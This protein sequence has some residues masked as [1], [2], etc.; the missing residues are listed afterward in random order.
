MVVKNAEELVKAQVG[1]PPPGGVSRWALIGGESMLGDIPMPDKRQQM[2]IYYEMYRQHP[3]VRAAV[4]KKAQYASSAKVLFRP[5]DPETKI[6]QYKVDKLKL[7]FRRSNVKQLLR[8]TYKDLDI[9]GESFWLVLR[10]FAREGTPQKA[11]RLNPRYMTPVVKNGLVIEW[12]YG[13]VSGSELPERYKPEQIL[14]FRLDDPENDVAGLSPLHSLQRAVAQDLFAMEYNESFFK[15]SAQTGTIFIVKTSTEAEAKR[16]RQW[17]KENY[18]GPD[19]AHR[20]LLLEGDVDVEKSVSTPQEMEFLRGRMLL[21]QEIAMVL[22]VDLE[23][24]GVHESSNR[25]VSNEV[26][27]SFHSESVWPR[28]V[29]LEEE[30]NNQLIQRI[31]GWSDIVFEQ[32]DRDPRRTQDQADTDDKNLKSGRET[33]NIQRERLGLAPVPGGDLAFVMTPTG[34]LFVK[35]FQKLAERQTQDGEPIQSEGGVGSSQS[36]TPDAT[37][38]EKA[39]TREPQTRRQAE[40]TSQND[41]SR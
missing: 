21:R 37:S 34:I 29:I 25:S 32:E 33:I 8:I 9:Y 35:N 4:D 31:F 3:V 20:P 30:I 17:L 39:P 24:L 1:L 23:K 18:T 26:D 12:K 7:F 36:T 28:Q 14:H 2:A 5:V 16:N 6:S 38:A 10:T 27:D 19:N 40:E 22:E 13:P 41:P 15:N 11:M